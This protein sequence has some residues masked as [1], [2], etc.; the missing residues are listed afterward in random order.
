MVLFIL[1]YSLDYSEHSLS[2]VDPSSKAASL[3]FYLGVRGSAFLQEY[4]VGITSKYYNSNN[5][6]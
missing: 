4:G 6:Q 3:C 1:H 2:S 5:Q